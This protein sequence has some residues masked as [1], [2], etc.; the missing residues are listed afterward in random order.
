MNTEN[1]CEVNIMQTTVHEDLALL[2]RA[3]MNLRYDPMCLT[4]QIERLKRVRDLADA[5]ALGL[6]AVAHIPPELKTCGHIN[7][8]WR[9]GA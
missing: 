3:L 4:E 6:E 9:T 1:G 8:S 5:L 2:Q 7:E